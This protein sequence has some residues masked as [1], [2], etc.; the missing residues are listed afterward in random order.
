M[1]KIIITAFVSVALFA[2]NNSTPADT[3]T[4][5]TTPA[6]EEN[7]EG[8]MDMPE[9]KDTT[10]ILPNQKVFFPNLKEGQTIKLPFILKF[11]VEGMEVKPAMALEP[12]V[13]HHHVVIDHGFITANTMFPMQKEAEGYYHFGKGQLQDTLSLKKYPMLTPGQHTITLQFA[14]S[15]HMSYGPAMSKTLTVTVK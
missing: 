15:M 13:G 6:I 14:N 3:T 4:T 10:A 1:K 11:G 12:N 5:A 2:C 9:V 7:H 8:H